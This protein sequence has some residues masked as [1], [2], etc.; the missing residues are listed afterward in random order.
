MNEQPFGDEQEPRRRKLDELFADEPFLSPTMKA[1]RL[2]EKLNGAPP[3]SEVP[4]VAYVRDPATIAPVGPGGTISLAEAA[5]YFR[6]NGEMGRV[7]ESQALRLRRLQDNILN[8]WLL[9]LPRTG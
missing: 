8:V 2:H 3:A 5:A 6:S 1:R 9:G 4:T 7:N